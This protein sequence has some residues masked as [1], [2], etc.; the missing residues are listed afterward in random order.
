MAREGADGRAMAG[1]RYA[2]SRPSPPSR[3]SIPCG[4]PGRA[5]FRQ[6]RGRPES[7][8]ALL[9]PAPADS[10]PTDPQAQ[11]LLTQMTQLAG[12]LE[13]IEKQVLTWART[14][15][16]RSTPLTDLEDRIHG[17]EVGEQHR[18][19]GKRKGPVLRL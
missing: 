15:L 7:S 14:P 4:H 10:A 3:S 17:H 13:R 8:L 6:T 12:D 11:K 18:E 16:N 1:R 2:I 5:H 9:P 19:P